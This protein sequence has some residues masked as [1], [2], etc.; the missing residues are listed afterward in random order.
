MNGF[1][2]TEKVSLVR[3]LLSN[4]FCIRVISF[5][6][7]CPTETKTENKRN[8]CSGIFLFSER[9]YVQRIIVGK[10]R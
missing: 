10:T 4:I 1:K 3:K 6:Q 5:W 8:K 9:K 7:T 2:V